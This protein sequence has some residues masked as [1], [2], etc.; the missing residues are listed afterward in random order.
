M[1]LGPGKYDDLCTEVREKINAK[2]TILIIIEGDRGFGFSVQAEPWI[3]L[4]LPETLRRVAQTIA[5]DLMKG[6]I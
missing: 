2:G 4:K 3:V 5:D 1:A 6:K